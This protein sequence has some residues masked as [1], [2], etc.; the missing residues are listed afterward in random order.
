A[1]LADGNGDSALLLT[2]GTARWDMPIFN[3]DQLEM[4][5]KNDMVGGDGSDRPFIVDAA[6]RFYL[7]RNHRNE[8][9]VAAAIKARRTQVTNTFAAVL[10]S[11]VDLLFDSAMGD[12]IEPQKRA[13]RVVGE[14]GLF[15]LTGGPGTG[16]T[17]TVLRMLLMLQRRAGRTLSIQA[18]APTGKAAQRLVQSLRAGKRAFLAQATQ[19]L[20]ED[21]P[22]YLECIPDQEAVTVH[23]LL[24]FQ[25][26]RNAFRNNRR[27]PIAAEVVV[28]DEA[29][30]IDLAMLRALLD[31]VRPDALLILVGDADQLTSVATGSVLMDMV[32]AME[33]S[34]RDDLVRL[35]HSFRAQRE[36]VAINEAVR[37]GDGTALSAAISVA[38]ENAS[39]DDVEDI[40]RLRR[41]LARWSERLAE[42]IPQ[43]DSTRRAPV[44][45]TDAFER[46]VDLV[47]VD[48]LRHAFAALA[49]QQLLC[50][51]RE[52]PFG[53]LVINAALE[54]SLRKQW[55]V[56]ADADW[57]HGR[58]VIIT[59]ND[60]T[61][62]LFNGDVGLCLADADGGLRVW[63]ESSPS[64]EPQ[65]H[66]GPGFRA[67]APNALPIHETAFAMTI[68]KSQGSE[69]RHVAVLLPPD[70]DHR[71]LSRQLLYTGLSRASRSVEI[72]STDRALATAIA[73][74]VTRAGGLEDR[75]AAD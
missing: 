40:A 61:A 73:T 29:S 47:A 5:R 72:W 75:L 12:E 2:D 19:P 27:H 46:P 52:G 1:S 7:Q 56:A 14:R 45:E 36:L 6:N 59:R 69:Y 74:P 64:S 22:E 67:F 48:E 38:A 71:I 42:S 9:A 63:F 13:V 33:A 15:V 3:A 25:P 51:L 28:I 4:L 35:L 17:T 23:R 18:A 58:A 54:R 50:A 31:A 68:H 49:E 41:A 53:S 21:W 57:Y 16:K 32:G 10:E 60:Y 20:P 8:C 30:M 66:T 11:D 26:W 44:D 70:S 55:N 39:R 65:G 43:S 24:G 34:Q 37:A 62:G